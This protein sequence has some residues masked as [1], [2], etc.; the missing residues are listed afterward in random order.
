M[1]CND[2]AGATPLL[3]GQD[4]TQKTMAEINTN[5]NFMDFAK[6]DK[7]GKREEW[8]KHFRSEYRKLLKDEKVK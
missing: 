4:M 1:V 6:A 7:I 3:R 8:Y 5:N 2:C